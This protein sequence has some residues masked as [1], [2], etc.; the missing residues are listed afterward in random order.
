MTLRETAYK[1]FCRA[2]IYCRSRAVSG[3]RPDLT[4][5]SVAS[6]LD[7]PRMPNDQMLDLPVSVC[8]LSVYAPW[9]SPAWSGR[10]HPVGTDRS[11]PSGRWADLGDEF[12]GDLPA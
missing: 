3:M 7:R 12:L 11:R 1:I 2:S 8:Q 4:A 5:A 9:A 6:V 10:Q